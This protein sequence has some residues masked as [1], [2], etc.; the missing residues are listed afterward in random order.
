M[1]GYGERTQRSLSIDV[2]Q[3][4]PL[5]PGHHVRSVWSGRGLNLDAGRCADEVKGEE[6]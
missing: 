5:S 6:R 3:T 2:H 1:F 4:L